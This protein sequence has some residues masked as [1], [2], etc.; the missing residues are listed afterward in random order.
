M[1]QVVAIGGSFGAMHVLLKIVRAL[2][3]ELNGTLL[4]VTHI[5][6]RKSAL[7]EILAK[8]CRIPVRDAQDGEQLLP[9]L[10]LIA[11]PDRH[12]LVSEDG[13]SIRLHDG[14]K[15]NHTRPAIDP[16]F[17]SVAK[18]Y[19][20]RAA[21]VILT[22]YLEDGVAG[23]RAIKSSGGY[24]MVQDPA[25]AAA[26]SMPTLALESVAVD[27]C[28]RSGDIGAEIVRRVAD[29]SRAESQ[30]EPQAEPQAGADALQGTGLHNFPAGGM[31]RGQE[32]IMPTE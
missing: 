28:L 25:E 18:A 9:G 26:S 1:H 31:W 7:A 3:R 24:A 2:P 23:L 14:P 15:E 8:D 22:G 20:A 10:V 19:G 16:L 30:A 27:L 32:L 12:M 21:G 13:G 11:P 29:G 4:V 17:R 6:A 5:G